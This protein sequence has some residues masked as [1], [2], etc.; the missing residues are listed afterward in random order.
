MSS[1]PILVELEVLLPF[2]PG[3]GLEA[4]AAH[5][6]V[7]CQLLVSL[8]AHERDLLPGGPLIHKRALDEAHPRTQPL[9]VV[10]RCS[11]QQRQRWPVSG[12]DA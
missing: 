10:C 11:G 1:K 6:F 12:D 7:E 5:L 8:D 9:L 2:V 4:L 3:Q